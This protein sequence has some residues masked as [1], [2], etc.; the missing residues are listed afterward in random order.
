MGMTWGLIAGVSGI[1]SMWSISRA[2]RFGMLIARKQY[3]EA[4]RLLSRLVWA[5]SV[6]STIVA[7]AVW[8]GIYILHVYYARIGSR[9]LAPFPCALFLLASI[10]L[11]ATTPLAVYLRA[12]KKEPLMVISV[13]YSIVAGF[14]AWFFGLRYGSLGIAWSYSI[15]TGPI[16]PIAVVAV[17]YKCR[18][19]WHRSI[20]PE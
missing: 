7:V 16:A 4:D 5:A 2:P 14:T 11:Q 8:T 18:S 6:V 9:L 13:V 19:D 1:T 12:H 10:P 3:D 17:W 20:G 15:L